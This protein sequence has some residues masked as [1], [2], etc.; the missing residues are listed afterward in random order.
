MSVKYTLTKT[1][2][3]MSGMMAKLSMPMMHQPWAIL[4]I[5]LRAVTNAISKAGGSGNA[6][7]EVEQ[8]DDDV[9]SQDP[10]RVEE[11]ELGACPWPRRRPHDVL[12]QS[13]RWW[14]LLATV[15]A[16]ALTTFSTRNR[17]I[18]CAVAVRV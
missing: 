1:S 9:D 14:P 7:D 12:A 17:Y 18:S 16:A 8:D 3:E 10:Q 13:Q 4:A 15:T 6:Q 2:K 11:V 5:R